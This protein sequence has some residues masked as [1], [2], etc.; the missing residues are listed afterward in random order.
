M[1]SL[2][3]ALAASEVKEFVVDMEPMTNN[4]ILV[5]NPSFHGPYVGRLALTEATLHGKA[6]WLYL[7]MQSSTYGV[8]KLVAI[9]YAHPVR[10]LTAATL[11]CHADHMMRVLHRYNEQAPNAV[12]C[13]GVRNED[14]QSWVYDVRNNK[15]SFN[16]W[17][18]VVGAC[19]R[20]RPGTISHVPRNTTVMCSRRR[21]PRAHIILRRHYPQDA[22]MYK[23]RTIPCDTTG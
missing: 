13:N 20:Y 2:R 11:R 3:A 1:A 17:S 7:Y 4:Q 5:R 6:V 8:A 15:I 19:S 18:R 22:N 14:Q 21:S 16:R 23:P 9:P 12:T 10:V